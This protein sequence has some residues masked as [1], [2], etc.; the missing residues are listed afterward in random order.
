MAAFFRRA[1][2]ASPLRHHQQQQLS[3]HGLAQTSGAFG[4]GSAITVGSGGTLDLNG[5]DTIVGSIGARA[6][7]PC[8]VGATLTVGGYNQFN[9]ISGTQVPH[10]PQRHRVPARATSSWRAAAPSTLTNAGNTFSGQVVIN[11][12]TLVINAMGELGTGTSQISVGGIATTVGLPGGA[13]VV[14]GGTAGLNFNRNLTITGRGPNTVG[15][16]LVSIGNNTFSGPST[17]GTSPR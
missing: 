5:F 15:A 4:I 10:H 17:A 13:L 9:N 1:G 2:P 6:M 3:H 11:D 16:S 12:G 8:P 14:Q 7:S